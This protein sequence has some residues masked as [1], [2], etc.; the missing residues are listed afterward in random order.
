MYNVDTVFLIGDSQ[1][2]SNNP[3]TQKFSSFFLVLVVDTSNHKIVDAACSATVQ[4]T[5][6][7]VRSMLIG[8]SI[9]ATEE[10]ERQ[11][12]LRYFGSSQ[13]AL[14]VAFKDA[15]KKYKLALESRKKIESH[16]NV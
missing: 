16:S 2:T 9:L 11:I 7:F 6:D 3:I 15:Q 12:R 5:S 14:I 13:K 10:I 8:M 1:T 4:I